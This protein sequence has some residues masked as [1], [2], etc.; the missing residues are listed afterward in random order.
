MWELL[1]QWLGAAKSKIN[2]P[3]PDAPGVGWVC[4]SQTSQLVGLHEVLILEHFE[5]TRKTGQLS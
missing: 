1:Q 2:I 4:D 3:Q 5:G